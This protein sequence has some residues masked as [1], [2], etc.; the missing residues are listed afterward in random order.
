VKE[1]KPMEAS[2][3]TLSPP[4]LLTLQE[5]TIPPSRV[6]MH[7]TQDQQHHLLETLLLVCQELVPTWWRAP[8]S[9]VTCE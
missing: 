1:K 5:Q 4:P 7:L 3:T 2:Q 9:E 6:W 8:E